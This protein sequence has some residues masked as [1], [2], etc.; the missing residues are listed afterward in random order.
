MTGLSTGKHVLRDSS[1][2]SIVDALP[3]ASGN[4]WIDVNC[5]KKGVDYFVR[6]PL[7]APAGRI[8][9]LDTGPFGQFTDIGSRGIT[10]QRG[11]TI[12]FRRTSRNGYEVVTP[13]APAER[14]SGFNIAPRRILI[15]GQSLGQ[16]WEHS[17]AVAAFLDR[18][19]ELGDMTPTSFIHMCMGGSAALKEYRPDST[20]YWWDHDGNCAGPL[21]SDTCQGIASMPA[22]EMPTHV[23]WIQG[24]QDS[25]IYAGQSEAE[26][27]EFFARYLRAITMIG[28]IVRGYINSSDRY[29]I[30]FYVQIL[31]HR[32]DGERRGMPLAR[33]AQW[34]LIGTD[35]INA[36]VAAVNPMDLP[37]RDGVHPT[38][39]GYATLGRLTAEAWAG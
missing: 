26:D 18:L 29:S 13:S 6:Y 15:I 1:A 4:V 8:V 19:V 11:Q 17:P 14:Q 16:E 9:A 3:S 33:D 35:G 23:L 24:E 10:I 25:G 30:P 36:R 31:G 2:G 39:D 34:A 21:L 7:S 38:D 20:R 5:I 22:A 12:R 32:A 28:K 27:Q 37:L